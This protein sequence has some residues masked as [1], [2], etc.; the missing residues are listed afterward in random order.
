MHAM[1]VADVDLLQPYSLCRAI[2]SAGYLEADPKYGGLL[3]ATMKAFLEQ[4]KS[5]HPK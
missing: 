1:D 5:K 4:I 3:L 2:Y